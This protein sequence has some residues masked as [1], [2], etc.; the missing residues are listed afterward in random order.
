MWSPFSKKE[1]MIALVAARP[2]EKAKPLEPHSMAAMQFS[3][4]SLVGLP[5]RE[6]SYF[7]AAHWPGFNCLKVVDMVI[8]GTTIMDFHC[9]GSWPA[10]MAS[11]EKESHFL[12]QSSSPLAAARLADIL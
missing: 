3:R 12:P 1:V 2:E 10:W 8:G 6:Y 11:V 5:D 4:H 7:P 9:S